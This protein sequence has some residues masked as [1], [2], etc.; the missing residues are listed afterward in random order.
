MYVVS[1]FMLAKRPGN[2]YIGRHHVQS[3]NT[4]TN[5]FLLKIFYRASDNMLAIG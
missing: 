3:G 2:G 4:I 5:E 1:R